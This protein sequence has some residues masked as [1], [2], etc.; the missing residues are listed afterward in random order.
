MFETSDEKRLEKEIADGSVA[1]LFY[2]SWCPDCHRFMPKF[3]EAA[4]SARVKV[5]KARIDE[6]ENPIWDRFKIEVVPTLILFE[7]GHEKER[8][9]EKGEGIKKQQL[10]KILKLR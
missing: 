5:G 6:D 4:K 3:D 10:E 9:E 1:V 8:A 2:A 7:G